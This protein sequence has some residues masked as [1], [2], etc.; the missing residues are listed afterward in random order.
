[1]TPDYDVHVFDPTSDEVR[2]IAPAPVRERWVAVDRSSHGARLVVVPAPDGGWSGAALVTSRPGA[3]YA[4]VV[5]VV[6]DVVPVL[7]AVVADARDRDLV[8]VKWEGWTADERVAEAAGFVR[9][10]D[11]LGLGGLDDQPASGYARWLV[12]ASVEEPAY[13]RQSTD[14][15]CGAVTALIAR[16]R[17]D[18][19]HAA[20]DRRDEL[21]LWRE[22]T[23]FNACEPVGLA[24]AVQRTWPQ[25]SVSVSLD[26][27]R[28]VLVEHLSD[29]EREWRSALQLVSRDQ[30]AE[31]DVPIDSRRLSIESLRNAIG[32]GEDVLLL[33]SL[34]TMQGFDVPHWVLAHGTAAGAVV[35]EDPWFQPLTGDSWVDAH[36]L[37]IADGALDAMARI[38]HDGFRG[39]VRLAPRP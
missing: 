35:I 17:A 18:G 37:P 26:V 20:F 1:M 29:A 13:Y 32:T 30:A 7:D 15:S 12:P 28:A 14:F 25:A 39:A 5:D 2:G 6:G 10:R 4:K 19:A 9:M 23:N 33:I 22:A 16:T 24:V 11:P 3:A 36:L 8:L 31:I 34:D 38:E 21:M 27:D